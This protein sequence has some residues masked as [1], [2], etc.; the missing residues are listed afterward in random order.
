MSGELVT[1]PAHIRSVYYLK[2]GE[3]NK[4]ALLFPKPEKHQLPLSPCA[5]AHLFPRHPSLILPP[6]ATET[7][8]LPV[9]PTWPCF[10]PLK[11]PPFPL[12]LP[13]CP[14]PSC[15]P[16]QP[17]NPELHRG[18]AVLPE[19]SLRLEEAQVGRTRERNS[20]D[21]E[22]PPEDQDADPAKE[23]GLGA[24][25]RLEARSLLSSR[26][27]CSSGFPTW[28]SYILV[29][30]GLSD[31]VQEGAFL[32]QSLCLEVRSMHV[33]R[34][35]PGREEGPRTESLNWD[36]VSPRYPLFLPHPPHLGGV[37]DFKICLCRGGW[38]SWTLYL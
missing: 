27:L 28:M 38:P 14:S 31:P 20:P 18:S 35:G 23:V 34:R 11:S 6:G 22:P 5:T 16:S 17:C 36:L 21:W 3:I 2:E 30:K 24:S 12:S 37:K 19:E 7:P 1:P 33:T 4:Q 10:P 29:I 9:F 32:C 13:S 15:L 26:G 25:R 8:P